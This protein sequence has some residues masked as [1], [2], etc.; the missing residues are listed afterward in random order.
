MRVTV[1]IPGCCVSNEIIQQQ[2]REA[3]KAGALATL[4]KQC[5][6]TFRPAAVKKCALNLMS[7]SG[8]CI[9][10]EKNHCAVQGK[11]LVAV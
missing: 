6:C 2:R 5:L 8:S 9:F 7:I 3:A 10:K 4:G 1:A 11:S